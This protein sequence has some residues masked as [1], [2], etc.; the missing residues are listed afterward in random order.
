M[1]SRPHLLCRRQGR[2]AAQ[3]LQSTGSPHHS[4]HILH[5]PIGC[6]GH[7]LS[8]P[9]AVFVVPSYFLRPNPF[10]FCQY[11]RT[12]GQWNFFR[13]LCHGYDF[14]LCCILYIYSATKIIIS[15]IKR[16][17]CGAF[18]WDKAS[19]SVL[20]PIIP[21]HNAVAVI[22]MTRDPASYLS[23]FQLAPSLVSFTS[24]PR[25]AS[26]LRMRSLVAQ[27]LAAFAF[28]RVSSSRSTAPA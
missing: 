17:L 16:N 27:S 7:T 14:L 23:N 12:V 3:V 21:C 13:F 19:L 9:L 22:P 1:K 25:R 20:S 24:N 6:A 4:P 8:H 2:A 10:Q 5:L 26:S 11:L 28:W 18:R 15:G